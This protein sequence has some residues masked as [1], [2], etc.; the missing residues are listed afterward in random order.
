MNSNLKERIWGSFAGLAV[1]DALGMPFHELTPD[2]I[3]SRC[4]G[5]VTTFHPIFDDEFIHLDYKPAQITDDTN[6]SIVTAKAILKYQGDLSTEQFVLELADWVKNNQA[7]WQHGGVYGPSTKAAFNEY[8]DGKFDGYLQ[9]KRWWCYQGTSNGA[10]MRVS[11]AG[12]AHPGN[13]QKAVEL[14]CKVIL[15]THPTDVA[16]SAAS[17]QAA[18]VS[19][20]LTPAATVGSIIDAA[21][22]GTRLGEEIGKKLARETSH[23]YPLPNLEI[24]LE[25]AEKA[26]DPF[27]AGHLIRRCIGS[28]LHVAETLATAMGIF[29][30]AKGDLQSSI[31]AAV[32]NGGDTDTIASI[33]G[34][35]AGALNGIQ[36]VP[37]EWVNTVEA[38]NQLDFEQMAEAF[39]VLVNN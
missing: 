17:G 10:I 7:V 38:F 21:L 26:K 13:W 35:L 9:R 2:E 14:A 27:E 16:L 24:A 23:R 25:L 3:T 30:A 32:N 18:A 37:K 15:P 1:G 33:V 29:Y 11:P 34:A 36:V 20:A 22:E 6:L 12:W 8:L 5:I 31:I 39:N 19:Q 28:H 4:G